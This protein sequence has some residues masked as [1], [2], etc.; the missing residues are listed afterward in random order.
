MD[1]TPSSGIVTAR[2]RP[3][4]D[5]KT[6]RYDH[7]SLPRTSTDDGRFKEIAPVS[8]STSITHVVVPRQ[9]EVEPHHA[10]NGRW[11]RRSNVLTCF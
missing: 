7:A 8:T 11:Q 9:D 3:L 10:Q 5:G 4:G 6:H 1:T 2:S